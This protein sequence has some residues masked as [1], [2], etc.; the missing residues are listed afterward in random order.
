MDQHERKG[1]T[2]AGPASAP[3]EEPS[4]AATGE[5]PEIADT[6]HAAAV[7]PSQHRLQDVLPEIS[8]LAQ[9]VGGLDQ[10]AR[11]IETLRSAKK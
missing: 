4:L 6:H 8:A 3:T 9:K 1:A 2:D 7:N 11:L 10:L 5:A